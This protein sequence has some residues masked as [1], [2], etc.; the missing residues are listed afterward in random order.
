MT[1]TLLTQDFFPIPAKEIPYGTFIEGI[2]FNPINDNLD[3]PIHGPNV[4]RLT[5]GLLNVGKGDLPPGLFKDDSVQ[6]IL[7]NYSFIMEALGVNLK[8]KQINNEYIKTIELLSIA[9]LYHDIGKH[10]R[11]ANHPQIGANLVRNFNQVEQQ[12]LVEALRFDGDADD[13]DSK[14]NRFALI[15]SIIQHHDKFGVVST[16]EGGLPIF[17][18]ILYFTSDQSSKEGIIKNITSVML[19]NLSDIAA[20]NTANAGN[21]KKSLEI[22]RE[23]FDIRNKKQNGKN[24]NGSN[25]KEIELLTQLTEICKQDESCLG[26]DGRKVSNVLDDWKAVVQAIDHKNVQGNRVQLKQQLLWLEKNPA[27]AIQRILRL[28]QEAALTTNSKELV[29]I[30]YISPTSVESVLVGTLGA[31]QFQSFCEQFATVVKLDY[32]LNFFKA[33]L[34]ATVR[35]AIHQEYEIKQ[36]SEKKLSWNRL[37]DDEKVLFLGLSDYKKSELARKITVLFIKVLESLVGRYAGVLNF[38]SLTPRRFGFQMRDLT[39]DEKIR[40]TIIDLLCIQEAKDSIA[41]TWIVD[42]V[43]IWS[44]D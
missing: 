9:A 23:V 22:A 30:K 17:S 40:D 19:L 18:D 4:I 16:G 27:R 11:R 2:F 32:G 7:G 37:N 14:H 44:F 3:Y 15:T 41:L 13:S 12:K 35:K 26:L 8:N 6:L 39:L 29:D 25:E 1:T 28:I 42:E 34:C 20:V 21:K 24:T 38:T 5:K 33:I 36:N 31:H 43:A 10:I